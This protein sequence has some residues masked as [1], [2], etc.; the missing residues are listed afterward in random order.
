[1]LQAAITSDI[2]TLASIYKGRGLRRAGGYTYAEFQMGLENFNRFLE[3][4]GIKATCFM[5]G[6][7][8]LQPQNVPFIQAMARE[9]HEIANHTMTHVQGFRLLS[10][11]EKEVEIAGMEQVCQ[12]VIGQIPLGFRSPGWNFG[13]D[14]VSILKRRGYLYDSS[15]FPSALNPLL[16][17]LHWRSQHGKSG[18]DRTTLGHWHY[19]FAPSVPYR[20]SAKTL[21]RRGHDGLIEF[22][23][24]VVPIVRLPFFATFL[25]AAGLKMFKYSYRALK[26][27]KRPIQFQF[28]LSDFVDYHHPSLADQ[29]PRTGDGVYVPQ[30]LYTPLADKLDL[31]RKAMD[32]IAQDYSLSTLVQWA[33]QLSKRD[34]GTG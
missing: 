21:L 10:T 24:P 26:I 27:L 31:F 6:A 17:L 9:G 7:D 33:R 20:T 29:V 12:D 25:L 23:Q 28:H 15:V 11:A 32:I 2:D 22:P 18:G 30:A 1:V 3:P 14:A 5:V 8:F 4:Y 34:N 16:K 13:D 19:M